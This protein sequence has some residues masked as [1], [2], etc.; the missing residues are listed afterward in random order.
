MRFYVE[1]LGESQSQRIEPDDLDILYA[2]AHAEEIGMDR[3]SLTVEQ[4]DLGL[5]IEI[6]TAGGDLLE[7]N[8]AEA[9]RMQLA[10]GAHLARSDIYAPDWTVVVGRG[11]AEAI[12]GPALTIE[13]ERIVVSAASLRIDARSEGDAVT[14]HAQRV[15]HDAGEFDLSGASRKVLRIVATEPPGYPWSGFLSKDDG[16]VGDDHAIDE[17]VRQLKRLVTR[18]K[19]GPVSS[20]DPALPMKIVDVLAARRRISPEMYK[21]GVE[22]GLITVVGKVCLLHPQQFGMNIVDLRERR[23]TPAIR[24]FLAGYLAAS[25]S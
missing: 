5:D 24:E 3:A 6:V 23:V 10:V 14:W 7:F 1:C 2:S 12:I 17:A 16:R 15:E 20:N 21:Y 22:T 8:V 18:F 9:S 19:P 4:T 25:D 13:C 11:G